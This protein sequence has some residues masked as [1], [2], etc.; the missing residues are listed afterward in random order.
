MNGLLIANRDE[1]A[2]REIAALF[3]D[4]DYQITTTDSVAN[5]LEGILEKTIQVVLLSGSYDEQYVAKFVPLL[6][7][8]NRNLSIILVSD[9]MPLELLRSIRKEGI[10]YHALRPA[11]NESWDEV[12]QAV[13]CAFESYHAHQAQRGGLLGGR[14]LRKASA[15]LTS[16]IMLLLAVPQARALDGAPLHDGGFLL[17]LFF[18][19]CALLIAAQLVPA[20]LLLLGVTQ[21]AVCCLEEE[22]IH[23]VSEES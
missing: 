11:A 18:G 6:K 4:S 10:F 5:A 15:V 22:D 7:K 20:V 2:R 12:T 17:L 21:R 13:G 3:T 1:E 14:S 16:L 9:E 19:F 23:V 8:C